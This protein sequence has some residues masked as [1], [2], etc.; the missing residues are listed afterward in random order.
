MRNCKLIIYIRLTIK[1]YFFIISLNMEEKGKLMK[2]R[3]TVSLVFCALFA[4]LTAAASQLSIPVGPVPINL[5][6]LSVFLAG[7]V[8]GARYAA[9]SQTVYLMIGAAGLPVFANFRAGVATL[10]G[11]TGGYLI[12]YVAA[13]WLIGLLCSRFGRKPAKLAGIL[14]AGLALCYL[15]GTAWFMFVTKSGLWSAMTLCV[16]PFLIGDAVKISAAVILIPRLHE[17]WKQMTI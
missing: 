10:A 17:I 15:L 8:L 6:T 1:A 3:T 7:G 16:L 9:V 4:A 2:N 11:P 12:G 13:A 5:A 14:C